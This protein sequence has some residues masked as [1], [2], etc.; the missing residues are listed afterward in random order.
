MN[1]YE[2]MGTCFLASLKIRAQYF[3]LSKLQDTG[4]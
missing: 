1:L 3:E 4:L 2:F